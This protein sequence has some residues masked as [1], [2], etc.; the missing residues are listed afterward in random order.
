MAIQI[1]HVRYQ[2]FSK[3]HESIIRYKWRNDATNAV[4]D[5]DKPSMVDFIDGKKGTA[6]VSD[7]GSRVAV[8]TV[9]PTNGQPYLRTYA[10]G[11]WTDNLLALPTF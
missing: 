2:G 8:G 9:H 1:T 10:D 5:N 11:K 4:G 3:N 7:G 6:Y